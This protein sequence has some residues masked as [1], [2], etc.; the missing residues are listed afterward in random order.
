MGNMLKKFKKILTLE[1]LIILLIICLAVFTRFF[2]L[3]ELP[4][5]LHDDEAAMAYDAYSLANWRVNRQMM[6]LPVYLP[7]YGGGQS[8]LYAYV[9]AVFIK[10]FGLNNFIIRLPAALF[11]LAIILCG[12]LFIKNLY[13]KKAGILAGFMFTIFPYFISQGRFGLD[14][15]LFLGTMTISLYLLSLAVKN[16]K[17][18]WWLITG[19]SFGLTLYSYALSWVVVPIFLLL[20][21]VYLLWLKKLDWKKLL[22][23]TG[24]FLVL[25]L[26][27]ILFVIVNTFHLDPIFSRFFY[28]PKLN[29]FRSDGFSFYG[30]GDVGIRLLSL[31]QSMLYISTADNF[32]SF[33]VGWTL[34]A[35]SIPFL[36]LGL[37]GAGKK[38]ILSLKKKKFFAES[39]VIFWFIGELALTVG[40]GSMLH[41]HNSFF[42]P[43]AFFII[44]GVIL[45]YQSLSSR[46]KKL[47]VAFLLIVYLI[48]FAGFYKEYFVIFP[49]QG[50][51]SHFSD[52]PQSAL[53]AL[54]NW[55]KDRGVSEE[56]LN[57][58]QIWIDVK[59]IF[60]Y[61]GAQVPPMLSSPTNDVLNEVRYKNLHFE[62]LPKKEAFFDFIPKEIKTEDIYILPSDGTQDEYLKEL[63]ALGLQEIHRD[64]KW[65]V[66]LD[67]K[68][69]K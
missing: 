57:Q 35:F 64:K 1:N 46:L 23:F 42:F 17:A 33:M 19:L 37:F 10:I 53:T 55:A 44:Y 48:S 36:V 49:T 40:V 16:Q 43:L 63:A 11:S 45:S 38:F 28:I 12:S 67:V 58:R 61:L 20:T 18:H 5:G 65:T 2:K 66:W 27:L 31:P 4:V 32:E 52:T 14:C 54:N 29:N 51:Q 3:T 34:Y 24:P 68:S 56:Q 50:Y 60:Y 15:N 6:H 47:W 59:Y 21:F 13:G 25:A 9:D 22:F 8:A 62:F 69:F 26:P 41:N 7:N 39:L 30:F